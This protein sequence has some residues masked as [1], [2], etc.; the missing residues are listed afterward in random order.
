M[1]IVVPHAEVQV[2]ECLVRVVLQLRWQCLHLLV[3]Q[4]DLRARLLLLQ[5]VAEGANPLVGLIFLAQLANAFPHP[6]LLLRVEESGT[7]RVLTLTL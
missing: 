5:E 1:L 3:R 6:R 4:A 7:F 2:E